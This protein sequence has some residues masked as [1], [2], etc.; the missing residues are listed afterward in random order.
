MDF[1]G[2]A[3]I[4]LTSADG[5]YSVKKPVTIADGAHNIDAIEKT[6]AYISG[7]SFTKTHIIIGVVND[8]N[9]GNVLK[10]LPEN[11]EYYFTKA[12]IPRAME[13]NQ[14]LRNASQYGLN[15][16]AFPTL[17]EALCAAKAR[18]KKMISY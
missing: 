4:L 13:E 10:I 5:G 17:S 1:K 6:I 2:S 7:F 3:K 14:L 8:K 18:L 11:A 12:N 9:W 16:K 15:G